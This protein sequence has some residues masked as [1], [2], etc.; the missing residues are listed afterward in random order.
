[1]NVIEHLREWTASTEE[2]SEICA[3]QYQ[4]GEA[5]GNDGELAAGQRMAVLL[6]A[7][8][9]R[10]ERSRLVRAMST[11][12]AARLRE[13]AAEFRAGRNPYAGED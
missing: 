2:W 11:Q 13:Q 3:L 5:P 7:V 1:M 9:G 12:D 10:I 6:D 8:A 4:I